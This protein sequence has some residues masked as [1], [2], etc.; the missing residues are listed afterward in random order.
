MGYGS[1]DAVARRQR[2]KIA[3]IGIAIR[4]ARRDR[5]AGLRIRLDRQMTS[6]SALDSSPLET[7][8]PA[9]ELCDDASVAS[10]ASM[11]LSHAG[12][13]TVPQRFKIPTGRGAFPPGRRQLEDWKHRAAPALFDN[14]TRDGSRKAVAAVLQG[15]WRLEDRQEAALIFAR[16]LDGSLDLRARCPPA[17]FILVCALITYTF[18]DFKPE[19]D[20]ALRRASEAGASDFSAVPFK[21]R[22]GW[23]RRARLAGYL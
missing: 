15:E 5:V 14:L 8:Q 16:S 22:W 21:G 11:P 6:V 7:K 13:R 3:R 20:L 1:R 17:W 23:R 19:F 12:A 10:Y 18:A 4:Q 2:A 9:E